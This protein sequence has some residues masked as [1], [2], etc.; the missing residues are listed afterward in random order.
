M[1]S[2]SVTPEQRFEAGQVWRSLRLPNYTITLV[3]PADG[4]AGAWFMEPSPSHGAYVV[5]ESALAERYTLE[6]PDA[7]ADAI[8]GELESARDPRGG[9]R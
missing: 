8:E 4:L 6:A 5:T 2:P 3:K 9:A 7:A 1:T